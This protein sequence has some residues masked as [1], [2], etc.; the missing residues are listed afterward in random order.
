[1]NLFDSILIS[2]VLAIFPFTIYFLYLIYAK[3]LQIEKSNIILDFVIFSSCYLILKYNFNYMIALILINVPLVVAYYGDRKFSIFAISILSIYCYHNYFNIDFIFLIAEYSIYYSL[4]MLDNKKFFDIFIIIKFLLLTFLSFQFKQTILI[5][6]VLFV[7]IKFL[8]Y[9]FKKIEQIILL[10]KALIETNENSKMY[11]SLFKIT[12]E[13]KNPIA[14]I[15]GYLDM[16]DENNENCKKY[17]P[18]IKGETNRVLVLLEDFL[19]INRLKIN[20]D[21]IDIS[22]LIE[23]VIT[24]FEPLL[25]SKHIKVNFNQ[26]EIYIE[27][28]YERLK[29]VFIN[30]IKNSIEAIND[31]GIIDIFIT[32]KNKYIIINVKDNGI[33][34]TKEEIEK[35]NYPFYTTKQNGTGLGLYLSKE[36]IKKHNGTMNFE[37]IDGMNISIKLPY[38][39]RLN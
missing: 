6:I 35:L 26:D 9:L 25:Q 7:I 38:D 16:Y 15:K 23:E 3:T 11:E 28:D 30:L 18:I 37:S 33:G 31:N 5:N 39:A 14:V 4:Y 34:M 19:S 13:I 32:L 36:I 10:H 8:L 29:Q 21:I 1:M 2:T 20:I 27:A 24:N 17:I 12:H 22:L